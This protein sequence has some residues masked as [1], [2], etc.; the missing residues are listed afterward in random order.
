[1]G[2]TNYPPGYLSL[3]KQ[4]TKKLNVVVQ[5]QGIDTIFS[6][7][8]LYEKI[9]YGDPRIHYGDPGIVY[10]GLIKVENVEPILMVDS[11]LSISQAI[12]PEQGRGS[13]ATLS[14][15]FVDKD[16]IMTKLISENGLVPEPLVN[17]LVTV[18]LGYTNSSFPGDYYKVFRGYITNTTSVAGMVTLELSDAN[19]KRRQTI[20]LGGTTTLTA[21]IDDT[22]TVIPLNQTGGFIDYI[23]GLDGTYDYLPPPFTASG[24]VTCFIQ[25]EDE[26]MTYAP[27]SIASN[28]ITVLTRGGSASRGSVP[29]P[30]AL[31]TTVTNN[32][33]F[34][35]NVIELGLKIMMSGFNGPWL[36]GVEVFALGTSLN[37]LNPQPNGILLPAGVDAVSDY[38]LSP[39]DWIT[40]L[41]STAGNNGTYNILE[42]EDDLG[43]PNR[44]LVTNGP[45]NLENPATTVSVDF[46]SQYDTLPV[47][48]GLKNTPQDVDVATHQE[49]QQLLFSSF[50]Q[51]VFITDTQNGQGGKDLIEGTLWLP[52]GVYT[53]TRYGQI[54]LAV[55][56]PPIAE[57][58]MVYLDQTNVLDPDK[59]KITR[60]VNR[61]RFY[62]VVTY[63]YDL[64]DAGN[65]ASTAV[66]IDETSANPIDIE[67]VLPITADGV[68]TFLGGAA[69]VQTRGLF[70]LNRYKKAAFEVSLKVNWS[71]ASIIEV[72]DIIA[73]V[74]NGHLKISNLETGE[75]NLG[76]QLF[77]VI[78]RQLTVKDGTAALTL[79]SNTGYQIGQRYATISPSSLV[80]S[81]STTS[82]IKI[83]DSFGPLYPGD[84]KKKWER[85]FNLPIVVHDYLYST[86]ATATLLG[87]DPADPYR[88]LVSP[89]FATPPTAGQIVDIVPYG[90]SIDPNYNALYKTLYTFIDPT[91]TVTAATSGTQF[92]VSPTD[93]QVLN[94]GLPVMVHNPS[95]SLQSSEQNVTSVDLTT[96]IVTVAGDLGFTPTA[97]QL[98]ELI[99]FKDGLGPY[100]YL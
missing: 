56:L 98:V 35:G 93:A 76:T 91:L 49:L 9:R 71:A 55:T 18:S 2:S 25:I 5:F 11:G 46:R 23:L 10:G 60:A 89:P 44:L 45:L 82:S 61:R 31:G 42:I 26:F 77:E 8:P 64:N 84:E 17:I 97:G 87:F 21:D 90:E 32:V 48:C 94:V 34:Q 68:K 78:Q 58:G 59:I 19:I 80:T 43:E 96:G 79:L 22:Q 1:M 72:G 70:I 16:G 100:R 41:G 95:Y 24:T 3:N 66:L 83:Q 27:N 6:L 54:S 29:M 51:Q 53:I 12:E 36:T 47:S 50:E 65:Y 92:A 88:M 13:V 30:H 4:S 75:R 15:N 33:Q 28:Q 67:S 39:G 74:D 14:L 85:L 62:N 7:V 63:Q 99:G 69:Q 20:F 40:V 37:P 73:L 38:G 52:V 81:G 86:S 57:Q